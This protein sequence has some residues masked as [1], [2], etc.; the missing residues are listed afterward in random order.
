MEQFDHHCPWVSNCI[1]KVL[2]DE[3]V[4]YMLLH[5][6]FSWTFWAF[7]FVFDFDN[8]E[9]GGQGKLVSDFDFS[10]RCF[11]LQICLIHQIKL[12]HGY[13]ACHISIFTKCISALFWCPSLICSLHKKKKKKSYLL[14]HL[15][16]ACLGRSVFLEWRC[17]W[18]LSLILCYSCKNKIYV[19]V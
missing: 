19:L 18:F 5:L 3:F 11:P 15:P 13:G 4:V 8:E 6:N 1:G 16:W 9:V 14:K 12:K 17:W 10:S 2:R 7:N